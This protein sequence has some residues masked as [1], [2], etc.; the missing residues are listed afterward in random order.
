MRGANEGPADGASSP[1]PSV[2]APGAAVGLASRIASATRSASLTKRTS[3][4]RPF[5]QR[6]RAVAEQA[7][8]EPCDS[9]SCRERPRA[10]VV[11][12]T[13]A[14][15]R[16]AGRRQDA[17]VRQGQQRAVPLPDGAREAERG[18]RANATA[19]RS[20]ETRTACGAEERASRARTVAVASTATT[21]RASAGRSA[22]GAA[23]RRAAGAR[24]VRVS[25]ARAASDHRLQPPDSSSCTLVPYEHLFDRAAAAR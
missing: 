21:A 14:A 1:G 4:P 5:S 16:R 9:R 24:R 18:P 10:S 20:S 17:A 23:C 11:C 3:W 13:R 8:A 22:R 7:P 2:F 19:S 25:C 12:S 15:P 6:K